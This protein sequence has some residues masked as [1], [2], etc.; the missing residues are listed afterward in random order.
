MDQVRLIQPNT[1]LDGIGS[2]FNRGQ[3]E[4]RGHPN[5]ITVEID[6]STDQ[7]IRREFIR[8]I[9]YDSYPG[10]YDMIHVLEHIF[11][12]IGYLQ[13]PDGSVVM[14]NLANTVTTSPVKQTQSTGKLI[15]INES[16]LLQQARI[17]QLE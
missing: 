16:A 15:N 9:F 17:Q 7:V 14:V 4:I 13:Q 8:V 6:G 3:Q 12:Q 2:I 5:G 10:P 11:Q 1:K